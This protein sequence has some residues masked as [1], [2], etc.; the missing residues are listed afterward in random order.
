[1]TSMDRMYRVIQKPVITEKATD[2]T[3][4]RNAYHFRVPVTAN[5]VEIRQAVEKLFEVDVLSVN[6]AR[7]R[8]KV[9]RRGYTAGATPTWKRAMVK[10]RE[11][12]TIEIL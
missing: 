5:K 7:V 8:G 1:V 2:D 4:G 11:G 3:A 6:T 12:Q 9:R 10:L